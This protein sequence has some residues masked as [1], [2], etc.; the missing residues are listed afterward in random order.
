[1]STNISI[2][3]TK[4]ESTLPLLRCRFAVAIQ[5]YVSALETYIQKYNSSDYHK[6]H[7]VILLSRAVLPK[8]FPASPMASTLHKRNISLIHHATMSTIG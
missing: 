8:T 4:Q 7:N 5:M 1:M 3:I 2:Q 6:Y